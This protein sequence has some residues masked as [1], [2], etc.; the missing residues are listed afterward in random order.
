[1]ESIFVSIFILTHNAPEYIKITLDSLSKTNFPD[2]NKEIIVVDNNS[3]SETNE[4]IFNYFKNGKIDKLYFNSENSFFA[5]GNN[6][7]FKLIDI[8]CTHVLLLNSDV[9]IHDP[10]WLNFLIRMKKN[11]AAVAFGHVPYPD[12]A[13]GYCFLIDRYLYGKHLL[14]EKFQWWYGITKLQAKILRED[15]LSILSIINHDNFLIHFGGKSGDDWKKIQ[16]NETQR[17]QILNWY[18][19]AKGNVD[20]LDLTNYQKKTQKKVR[21]NDV[22]RRVLQ[23][24]WTRLK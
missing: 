2:N 7:A 1:M 8:R 18:R 11:Y 12:R 10:N 16:R 21:I 24:F 14:D 6:I 9:E 3:D 4:I 22:A 17:Y 13:D 15:K 23:S 19:K 5:K 20:I